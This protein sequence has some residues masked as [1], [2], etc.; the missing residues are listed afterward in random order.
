MRLVILRGQF[1]KWCG[2][3]VVWGG[4]L[5]LNVTQPSGKVLAVM[6][7]Y[8]ADGH[9]GPFKG[10]REIPRELLPVCEDCKLRKAELWCKDCGRYVCVNCIALKS[11]HATCR[12]VSLAVKRAERIATGASL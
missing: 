5:N 11:V 7:D 4:P 1:G 3:G 12:L 9:P 2:L 8:S 6:V 10:M